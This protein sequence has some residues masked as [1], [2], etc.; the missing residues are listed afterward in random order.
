MIRRYVKI[1]CQHKLFSRISALTEK[2]FCLTGNPIKTLL[3]ILFLI[4]PKEGEVSNCK[5]LGEK[6]PQSYLII[7]KG[8]SRYQ[9][10]H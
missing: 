2:S 4:V 1:S 10:A 6:K 8:C 5:I 9:F 7:I 3:A